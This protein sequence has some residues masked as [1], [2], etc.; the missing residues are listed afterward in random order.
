[1]DLGVPSESPMRFTALLILLA[2]LLSACDLG[3]QL[4]PSPSPAARASATPGSTRSPTGT[5][6]ETIDRPCGPADLTAIVGWQGATGSMAGAVSFINKSTTPCLV[7]GRPGLHLIDAQG[8]LMPVA[9]LKYTRET[10][11]PATPEDEGQT[12]I[13]RPKEKAFVFFVWSNWC[14]GVKGPFKVVVAMPGEAGQVTAPALGPEGSPISTTPRCD[15]SEA[16]STISVGVFEL[17]P[18]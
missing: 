8:N 15:N 13:L 11:G 12:L 6:G 7:Q 4:F 3:G 1:M 14:G 16:T 2:L 17:A 10:P 9:N 5:P 18:K